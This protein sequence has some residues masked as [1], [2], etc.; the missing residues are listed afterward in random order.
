MSSTISDVVVFR[1]CN[2]QHMDN[3]CLIR[4]IENQRVRVCYE[5]CNKDGCNNGPASR[6]SVQPHESHVVTSCL[7]TFISV[8][9]V[10]LLP[11]LTV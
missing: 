6:S 3:V 11:I 10:Y 8:S 9:F 7:L 4:M 5:T 1:D 2:K